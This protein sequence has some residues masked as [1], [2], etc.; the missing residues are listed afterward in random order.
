MTTIRP[1]SFI[2]I[3]TAALMVA[4]CGRPLPSSPPQALPRVPVD[5]APVGAVPP[6]DDRDRV[7]VPPPRRDA[8]TD[9]V[10]RLIDQQRRASDH[11]DWQLQDGRDAVQQELLRQDLLRRM[12]YQRRQEEL[13][14]QQQDA[15]DRLFLPGLLQ[16]TP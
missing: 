11:M 13:R 3:C 14:R 5:A 12:E 16:K 15:A 6:A 4:G 7:E 8:V 10:D 1:L 9:Q 2:L